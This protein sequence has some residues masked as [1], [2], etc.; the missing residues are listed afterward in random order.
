MKKRYVVKL[1]SEERDHL[2]GI[3]N[4]GREAAYRRRHAQVLLLV[5]DTRALSSMASHVFVCR[6]CGPYVT[7][8]APSRSAPTEKDVRVRVDVFLK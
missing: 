5:D 4:R 1:T 2:K 6:W 7:I 3:I 8:L